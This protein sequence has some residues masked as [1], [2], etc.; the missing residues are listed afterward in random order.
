MSRKEKFSRANRKKR[1][2]K[3]FIEAATSAI[4]TTEEMP[5]RSKKHPSSKQQ[6]TKL[7]YNTL[8]VLFVLLVIVLFWYGLEHSE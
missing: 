1:I 2:K 6:M 4:E 7:F 3:Q 8:F 5:A